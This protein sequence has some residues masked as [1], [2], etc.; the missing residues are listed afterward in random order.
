M[1]RRIIEA[2]RSEDF[3]VFERQLNK[4]PGM[5]LYLE[6][7][8]AVTVIM[9]CVSHATPVFLDHLY[10]SGAC[11]HASW[12]DRDVW[13]AYVLQANP[14]MMSTIIVFAAGRWPYLEGI[15]AYDYFMAYRTQ[16]LEYDEIQKMFE[17]YLYS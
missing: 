7:R 12:S 11:P 10:D 16:G 1:A 14:E 9:S 3:E 4:M 8:D 5:R 2:A 6:Y 17:A 13:A 15:H